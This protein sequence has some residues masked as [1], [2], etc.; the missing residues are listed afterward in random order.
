M[1]VP[2][3]LLIFLA[4]V[5]VSPA[6]AQAPANPMPL[7]PV[8][9]WVLDYQYTQCVAE[10][11]F[12][13]PDN[14]TSLAI[15]PAPNTKTYELLVARAGQGP[16][17]AQELEGSVDFGNGPIKAWLLRYHTSDKKR[18]LYI[19]RLPTPEMAQSRTAS[20]VRFQAKGS[21]NVTVMLTSMAALMD[22]LQTCAD[23]LRRYWNDGGHNDGRIAK[24]AKGDVRHIFNDGDFPNE[25]MGRQQEG[26]AQFVLLIDEK[27]KVAACHVEKAS[28]IPV[29]DAMGC[30]VIMERAKF[31]PALD[32]KG[33]PIRSMYWTP[34]VIWRFG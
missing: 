6:V 25:A 3:K 21:I 29:F 22:G 12:G 31:K 19:F 8:S 4:I 7:Q 23:D 34:E 16:K 15:R 13:S 20:F 5:N 1:R 26:K 10:R 24:S 17:F 32:A 2:Q 14:P 28:G 11:D 9:K 30:Q 33:N 27:G 18:A